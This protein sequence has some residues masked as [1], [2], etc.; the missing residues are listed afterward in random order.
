[1][2][3]TDN[4]GI[5]DQIDKNMKP[6]ARKYKPDGHD[7][8]GKGNKD[9]FDFNTENVFA[10]QECQQQIPRGNI[11]DLSANLK[12][13]ATKLKKRSKLIKRVNRS[14]T[15]WSIVQEYEQGPMASDSDD[16]QKIRQAELRTI[17]KKK[18][19]KPAS[20]TQSSSSM[21]KI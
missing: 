5:Q 20:F 2:L 7:M 9:Q 21:K 14:P 15:G 19:K 13:I 4:H 1:M 12:S 10:I 6:P 18:V 8:E 11:E 3:Q 16:A 17:R